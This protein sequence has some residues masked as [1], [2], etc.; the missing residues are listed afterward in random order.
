MLYTDNLRVT[1]HINPVAVTLH[2]DP[3]V[4]ASPK[5]ILPTLLNH[6]WRTPPKRPTN[7]SPGNV[8][9]RLR[10]FMLLS[11]RSVAVSIRC[12]QSRFS[13]RTCLQSKHVG[14]LFT[15]ASLHLHAR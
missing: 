11:P 2:I 8:I 10:S 6:Y 1:M 4:V 13:L 14:L 12:F 5:L 9:V 7:G 15:T 3:V